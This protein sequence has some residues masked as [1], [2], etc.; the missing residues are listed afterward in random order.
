MATDRYTAVIA[1]DHEIVRSALRAAFET[2]GTIEPLGIEVVAEAGDGLEAVAAVKKFRPSVVSL[3][4]SMPNVGGHEIIHEIRRWSPDTRI[5]VFTGIS[6]AGLV[7]SIIESGADGLFSKTAASQT[8]Y[9][10]LPLILRGGKHV[11]DKFFTILEQEPDVPVLTAREHQVLNQLVSGRSNREISDIL[12]ISAKTV[13]KHRGSLMKKL[14][15]HSMA[16]LLARALK[17]GLIDPARE[18]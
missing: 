13:E 5:V 8:I 18:I 2:P 10:K 14:N 9:Q 12:G 7:A 1:D 17:D 15:V 4:V 11:D 3:D 16:Q 6:A